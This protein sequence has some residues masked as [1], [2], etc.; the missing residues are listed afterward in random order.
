MSNYVFV[1]D[2]NLKPLNPCTPTI[3]SKLLDAGK[4][5]V[6]RR[7]PFSII[8]KKEANSTPKTYRLKLDPGSKTTGIAI[9][10]DNKVIWGAELEHRGQQ[11]KHGL[12]SRRSL[13]RGRRVRKTRY[14]KPRF[15]NRKHPDSWLS[16]SLEHR[17][18]TTMTW[19]NRLIKLCPISS[20]AQELVK[21]DTH[22]LQNPELQEREYQQGTLYQYE[23]REY[24]LEKW[25]HTCAYCATKDVPL[26]VEHIVPRSKGGSNR[27]SNL[28]IACV[29]CNQAKSNHDIK[30]FLR[31]QPDLLK[32]LLAQA[33]SPLKDAAAVNSTRW[34][35]FNALKGTGLSV[36]TATGGQ[37][38]F[39]RTQQ[40]L[41]KSHWL[42]AACVGDIPKL[43][44]KVSQPL[45]IKC[46]GHGK[47]QVMQ[48]DKYGFQ[49]RNKKGELVRKSTKVKNVLGFETGDLVKAVVTKG[50]K[51]G[52]YLGKVAIRKT[53]SF[54]IKTREGTIE[55]I[56][57]KY[58]Q[59]IHRKDGY[60]YGLAH[61]DGE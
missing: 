15:N 11:I 46:A 32:R 53:G 45:L 37:T 52:T 34:K 60:V 40:G 7:Y 38:K 42:D 2:T 61:T 1:L 4:A 21:F 49:K 56:S 14:R 23:V 58:C 20:I 12:E 43:E 17:V 28:A 51:V 39:N 3:A 57:W 27:I 19:V 47:R 55:G 35:L 29:P 10:Q 13:R 6:F 25:H 30:D 36:T 59:K 44:V 22:K 18:L 24:L 48:V 54:N 41:P 8:L 50:K 16:P 5:A 26:E 33:K 9:L 31:G